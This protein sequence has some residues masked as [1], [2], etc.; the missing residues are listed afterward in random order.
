[1]AKL[2]PGTRKRISSLFH[3]RDREKAARLLREQC[4]NNLP[5]LE[6]LD[7]LELERFRFAAL[8][9]SGGDLSILRKAIE[10]GKTDWRDLLVSAGFG[11]NIH[12]HEKWDPEVG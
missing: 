11:E 6:D 7:E 1:M 12:A 5:L 2:S 4:G 9:L 10:L 3:P 8:K